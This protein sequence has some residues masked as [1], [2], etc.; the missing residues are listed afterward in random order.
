[1]SFAELSLSSQLL[2]LLHQAKLDQPTEIQSLAIPVAIEG[3]DVLA[4]AQTGSGKTLAFVL[5]I[6]ERLLSGAISSD[7]TSV[8][9]LVPTR[10]LAVQVAEQFERFLPHLG[11]QSCLVYG[12]VSIDKQKLT[13]QN[14]PQVVIA[15]PGRLLDLTKRR[16]ID[17]SAMTTLVFDE[18]DRMFEMGFMDELRAIV[19]Y[20]PKDKQTML[21]SA[22]LAAK[23]S[24]FAAKLMTSPKR[25]E[26][27]QQIV[28]TEIN[29]Q[30]YAVDDD[31]KPALLRHL[32]NKLN[33]SRVLVFCRK[34]VEVDQLVKSLVV[35][36]YQA[37]ALHGDL[38]Q[39]VRE[40]TLADFKSNQLTVLVATDVAAR[41]IDIADL[42]IVV[43]YQFPFKSADYI[44]RIGRTGRAGKSGLAVTFY[45]ESDQLLLEEVEALLDKR[46]PQQ[47]EQGFEPDLTKAPVI[48]GKNSRTAQK[49]R[50]K[51]RAGRGRRK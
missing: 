26:S 9:V 27:K 32:I 34:K 31:K 30:V 19:K 43:N 50:A 12:G 2:S 37:A 33:W 23:V 18:A 3:G 45:S 24:G 46:L 28:A 48:S 16:A 42:Q 20:L 7:K 1:M 36:G 38:S 8:L 21:F 35:E 14:Q 13:L 11:W 39:S 10:E 41:G 17:L 22:T 29:Q 5:P 15:T 25:V 6:V 4:K 49:Q 40:Q 51:R 44:H 47:W